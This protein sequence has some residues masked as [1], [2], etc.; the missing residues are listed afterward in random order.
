M[1]PWFVRMIELNL[2][3]NG[4]AIR[5]YPYFKS[6]ALGYDMRTQ[7]KQKTNATSAPVILLLKYNN[8]LVDI[9]AFIGSQWLHLKQKR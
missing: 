2:A 5:V 8:P 7:T 9:V 3:T 4:M 1:H 6:T